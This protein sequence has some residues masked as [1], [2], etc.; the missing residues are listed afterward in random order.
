M[1][2]WANDSGE[3][4]RLVVLLGRGVASVV[5]VEV[6]GILAPV[7]SSWEVV[8]TSVWS[9]DLLLPV[10]EVGGWFRWRCDN[11]LFVSISVRFVQ[12]SVVEAKV[13]RCG[14]GNG[15]IDTF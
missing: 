9:P 3:V 11:G 14:P 13:P 7:S 12:K 5:E 15:F 4:E 2:P 6:I 10:V 8:L 1:S